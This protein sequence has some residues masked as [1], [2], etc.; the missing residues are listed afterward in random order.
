MRRVMGQL[1]PDR[2]REPD[3]MGCKRESSGGKAGPEGY[4]YACACV[5]VAVA[6]EAVEQRQVGVRDLGNGRLGQRV[7]AEGYD[8]G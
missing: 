8:E 1:D 3:Y 6:H 4:V 7:P 5:W 2:F